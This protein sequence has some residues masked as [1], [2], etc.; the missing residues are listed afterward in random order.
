MLYFDHITHSELALRYLVD[1]VGA[2]HV[3]I[4]TDYP[5]DMGPDEPVGWLD[6][7]DSLSSEE[8]TAI[9]RENARQFLRIRP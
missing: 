9:A 7:L 1:L 2:D 6:G 8:K 5:F 3:M 4:G